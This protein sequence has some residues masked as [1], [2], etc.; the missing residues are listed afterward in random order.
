MVS[1]FKYDSFDISTDEFEGRIMYTPT[2]KI[3]LKSGL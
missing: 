3:T 1:L 2:T